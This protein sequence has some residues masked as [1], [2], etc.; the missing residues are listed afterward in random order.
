M[1][2]AK[3]KQLEPPG[4]W[5]RWRPLRWLAALAVIAIAVALFR[6]PGADEALP[7]SVVQED[8]VVAPAPAPEVMAPAAESVAAATPEAPVTAAPPTAEIAPVAAAKAPAPAALTADTTNATANAV[9][10]EE[11]PVYF[12]EEEVLPP[13]TL[14][15]KEYTA[16]AAQ[17]VTLI[18]TFKSYS[19]VDEIH[20][21]LAAG[22]EEPE[23]RSNHAPKRQGIPP[24]ELDVLRMKPY[25]HLGVD[26]TLEL[27]F[28]NDRLYQAE[29]EPDDADAYR[30]AVRKALPQLKR[31]KSGRSER[32]DV[33]LRIAS[34]MELA[35][36]EVGQSLRTR[37]FVLWQDLRLVRQRDAWDYRYA[38]KA[39]N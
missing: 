3:R 4:W 31:A 26:G 30:A 16:I 39:V 24:R 5:K 18:G 21:Q 7:A 28:F 6:G 15:E 2:D 27:Q 37:P 25:R 17:R 12:E 32:R 22:G 9:V 14:D 33:S 1:S 38:Q 11:E 35:V 34:S 29:F 13:P 20:R 8:V 36:S 19:G 10:I 23:L